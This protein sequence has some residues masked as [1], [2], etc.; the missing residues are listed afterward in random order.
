MQVLTLNDYLF[1]RK[2]K[3][4]DSC[5]F[6]RDTQENVCHFFWYCAAVHKFWDNVKEIITKIT[7]QEN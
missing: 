5:Y 2:I 4:T 7:Y 1:D 3:S 6:C